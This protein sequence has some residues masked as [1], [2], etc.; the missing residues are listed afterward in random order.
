VPAEDGAGSEV[1]EW[2]LRER[3]QR[4][5]E[6]RVEAEEL[7]AEGEEQPLFLLT[8]SSMAAV[9]GNWG[10]DL[11][12]FRS[13]FRPFFGAFHI[14]SGQAWAEGKGGACKVPPSRGQQTGKPG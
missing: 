13:F 8:P 6:R 7:C 10:V 14:F 3:R 2:E 5:V 11:D 9:E 1:S 4:E 12:F